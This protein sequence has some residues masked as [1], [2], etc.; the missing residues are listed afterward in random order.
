MAG[1]RGR[2]ASAINGEMGGHKFLLKFP[3]RRP[4]GRVAHETHESQLM[5]G[6]GPTEHTEQ[7]SFGFRVFRVF[8]GRQSVIGF[9]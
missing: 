1:G 8:R 2:E 3:V 4:V 9:V 6:V 5:I 7:P